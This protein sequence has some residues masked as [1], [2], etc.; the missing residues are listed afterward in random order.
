[1]N[2]SFQKIYIE[3]DAENIP[4]TR[5]LL[6]RILG[7]G[8]PAP[9]IEII[10][11]KK[12]ILDSIRKTPDPIVAGKQCL[13]LAKDRGLAFKPFPVPEGTVPC[14]FHSLHLVEGCDLECSYCILQAYLTNPAIT[15]H[16]NVEEILNSL[17]SFLRENPGQFFR[18]GTGQLADSLSLDPLTAHSELLIPFFARQSNALL[19]LK[20]KS[21]NIERLEGLDHRNHTIVSWSINTRKI[22]RE[23]EHKCASIDERLEAAERV[24]EWGYSVG[25]HL[26]PL[27]DY[28]GCLEE[29]AALI[30][31]IFSKVPQEKIAWLS[32]GTLRFMPEL[33]SIMEKRFPKSLLP[34]AEWVRGTDGKMRYRKERRVDFYHSLTESVRARNSRVPLYFCME[35]PEVWEKTLGE[36][37]D[38]CRISDRLDS[39]PSGFS[40]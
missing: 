11:D 32:F 34:Y 22:Q 6:D 25:F 37:P 36:A 1:M 12:L 7:Q 2:S 8:N 33:K 9:T 35:T 14:N 23:E 15:V 28:E 10:R 5:A 13:F 21:R 38:P 24:V 18:I 4:Y 3:R 26:D 20:T 16:V 17:E 40:R 31:E 30:E 29:Y 39:V 27:I 19:E